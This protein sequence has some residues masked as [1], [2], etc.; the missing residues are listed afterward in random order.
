MPW[1]SFTIHPLHARFRPRPASGLIFMLLAALLTVG[2]AQTAHLSRPADKSLVPPNARVLLMPADIQLF[3]VT[4]GGLLEPKAD[5]TESAR[6]N[7]HASLQELLRLREDRLI[8]YRAPADDAEM[9]RA[10]AQLVKLHEAVGQT[11]LVHKYIEGLQLPT[12]KDRMEWS[13]GPGAASLR[14]ADR[15]DCALFVFLRDSYT[16]PGRAAV[17]AAGLLLGVY[18]PG[19]IQ[20][21][22]ASLVDLNS[23]EIL[24]FNRLVSGTGDLRQPEPAREAVTRL[25][26]QIPL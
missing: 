23:G 15:A 19:G 1:T 17:M 2:C 13:L 8:D 10:H 12:M 22:F 20:M 5:W 7:V 25:L 21:G 11:I 3:E 14:G 4:A 16:S 9:A 24:W 6:M 18:I 26:S